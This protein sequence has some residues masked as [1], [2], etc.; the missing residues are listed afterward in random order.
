MKKLM[1]I[2]LFL[3]L[4]N[5]QAQET[6]IDFFKDKEFD[7]DHFLLDGIKHIPKYES[8]DGPL[9]EYVSSIHL[10][11][12]DNLLNDSQLYFSLDIGNTFFF[13]VDIKDGYYEVI[14]PVGQTLVLGYVV[15]NL[16]NYVGIIIG[17]YHNENN[18]PS[19]K[20]YY[21]ID[22]NRQGFQLYTESDPT[23]VLVFIVKE[24]MS[25]PTFKTK[26]FTTVYYDALLKKVIVQTPRTVNKL[27]LYSNLGQEITHIKNSNTLKLAA[28]T[29]GVY[30]VKIDTDKG[31]IRKQIVIN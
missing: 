8:V 27:T 11:N 19:E 10:D 17:N 23:T 25:A 20:V 7:F 4:T 31:C 29:T 5:L 14:S 16:S 3:G 21:T 18:A 9:E 24:S 13:T 28:L 26:D 1:Y 6:N 12:Y 22:E 30:L 15:T 2:C